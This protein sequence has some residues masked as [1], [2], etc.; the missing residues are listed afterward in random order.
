MRLAFLAVLVLSSHVC[1]EGPQLPDWATPGTQ[2]RSVREALDALH[3]AGVSFQ[4]FGDFAA[5]S[6][7]QGELAGSW[8][9]SGGEPGLPPTRYYHYAMAD[10]G[11]GQTLLSVVCEDSPAACRA[12]LEALR[13][14]IAPPP[15]PPP[16]PP[17]PDMAVLGP[18]GWVL[19]REGFFPARGLEPRKRVANEA[20]RDSDPAGA[21]SI[22]YPIEAAFSGLSGK[23]L[24]RVTIDDKGRVLD[25]GIEQTSRSWALDHAAMTQAR[26]WRFQ[27]GIRNGVPVGGP[28]LVPVRFTAPEGRLGAAVEARR[29]I[30]IGK[31]HPA[32]AKARPE[33]VAPARIT[34]PQEARAFLAQACLVS[35][36]ERQL[37]YA[38]LLHSGPD[39]HSFWTLFDDDSHMMGAVIRRRMVVEGDTVQARV[40]YVCAAEA[41]ACEQV[42]QYLGQNL[43]DFVP[44]L[45]TLPSESPL[46]QDRC[47]PR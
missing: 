6:V 3:E 37:N 44:D 10:D 5:T 22:R 31:L 33:L 17:P 11:S 47:D 29:E 36:I 26:Q 12:H 30:R 35:E 45:P 34:R 42:E 14:D 24:L 28:V 40:S 13:A 32:V 20:G 43:R 21:P 16:P 19:G 4:D 23:T 27:P 39:G 41:G 1:A 38:V 25:V 7:W 15:V 9:F 46:P 2:T 18:G 8:V